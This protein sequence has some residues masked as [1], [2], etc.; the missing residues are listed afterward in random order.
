MSGTTGPL[1]AF[2]EPRSVALVGVSRDMN[3]FN[4]IVLKNL[5][6]IGYPGT[7]YLVNPFTTDIL[8]IP[9]YPRIVDLPEVPELAVILHPDVVP[10][11]DNCGKKGIKHV[12]I[13]ADIGLKDEADR[14]ATGRHITELARQHGITFM[15]P[16]IIGLVNFPG[17]FTTS[18]I[19]VRDR[20]ARLG[21]DP[22]R[23]S[24]AFLAQSGGL[25]GACGWWNPSQDV[26]FSKVA[27]FH[28]ECPGSVTGGE[29][30]DHVVMDP[31][32]KV[33]S[34]F[35]RHVSD[36]IVRAVERHARDVPVLFKK[37]GQP[38]GVDALR[39]A[40]ALEVE[41][42]MDLF[43]IAKA[44]VFSPVPAGKRIG[45]IGPSS[46]AID[47][48]LSEFKKHGLE[49]ARPT[50]RVEE[51]IVALLQ[52]TTSRRCNPVDFWPPPRFFGHEVGKVH[53]DATHLLL[54]DPN[55][56]AIFLVLEFFNEIEFDLMMLK[57][58]ISKHPS[59]PVMGVLIQA[60]EDGANRVRA[61]ATTMGIPV[62]VEPER[63][64][65]A[66]ALLTRFA[67]M[68]GGPGT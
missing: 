31:R 27:H 34:L 66:Y 42:Y 47:V 39:A 36:S 26:S 59:K 41:T 55:V 46:G 58:V 29:I 28:E 8:G 52:R 20:I 14:Q 22:G 4:G 43:E 7:I 65:R 62:F 56:D 16:S 61:A 57:D 37:C 2:F 5:L 11:L 44:F 40:G 19:P 23:A 64:V 63:L 38:A 35:L 24:I 9:C 49:I 25:A 45:L 53:R 33:V 6:E 15:G 50:P 13:Q 3:K 68:R 1:S 12:I 67:A 60:E 21:L 54:S 51:K 17:R 48:V 30:L 18:I 10:I 32:V